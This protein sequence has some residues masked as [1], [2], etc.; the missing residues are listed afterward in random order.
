MVTGGTASGVAA[1]SFSSGNPIE[2]IDK[3]YP[4]KFR[5]LIL[6]GLAACATAEAATVAT[7]SDLLYVV[8]SGANLATLVIDFNDGSTIDSFAWGFRWDGE[9]SGADMLLAITA[10]DQ[11]IS[12]VSFGNG[13]SGFFFS[14]LSYNDGTT[15]HSGNSGTFNTF[16]DDYVSWGY[17][18]SGGFADGPLGSPNSVSGGGST[19]PTSWTSAPTGAAAESFGVTGRLLTNGAWDVWSFGANGEDF[20]H[21]APPSGSPAAAVPEPAS[22][23]LAL[24]G[25]AVM[26]RRKR[27]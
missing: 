18:L 21:L 17:Y 24:G 8:G 9:A 14:S 23:L 11:R 16:P 19:L 22:G 6:A 25:L 12:L 20:S 26:L 4:M 3:S 15:T 10:A 7:T 1:L 2:E 13:D 5:I 27:R